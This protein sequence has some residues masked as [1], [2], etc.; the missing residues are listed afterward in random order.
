QFL[1]RLIERR[2]H[3][4][5]ALLEAALQLLQDFLA[6]VIAVEVLEQRYIRFGKQREAAAAGVL[7]HVVGIRVPAKRFDSNNQECRGGE[8]SGGQDASQRVASA[9]PRAQSCERRQTMPGYRGVS[10]G[11]HPHPD[12]G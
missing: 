10:R 4:L 12:G 11:P 2:L 7:V 8:Q 6:A 5:A 3:G 1:A 9:V